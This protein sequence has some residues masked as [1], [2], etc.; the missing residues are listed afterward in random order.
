ML[1]I[2]ISPNTLSE[3]LKELTA[4]GLLTRQAYS[5]VPLRVEYATTERADALKP[6]FSHLQAWAEDYRLDAT[7]GA[8]TRTP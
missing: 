2:G 8:T 5:E 3:R 1:T 7:P 6:V 4:A